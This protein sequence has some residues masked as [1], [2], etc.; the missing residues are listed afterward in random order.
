M[1]V[2]IENLYT[3]V[4]SR[5]HPELHRDM[6]FR[7]W[8]VHSPAHLVLSG[9]IRIGLDLADPLLITRMEISFPK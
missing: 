1:L 7:N 9:K 5:N 2:G 8:A 3:R 6:D 4:G